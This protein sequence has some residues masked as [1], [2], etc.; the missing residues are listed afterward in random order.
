ML[1]LKDKIRTIPNFPKPGIMFRD[2]TTLLQ[3][4]DSLRKLTDIFYERYKEVKIDAIAGIESRG[5]ILAGILAEK[6]NTGLI[7][8]RK[9]GK[10]PYETIKQE[11]SLEYG[12][13]TLEIHKDAIQPGQN[14][15]L[16]D[17]L[18]ATGGTAL[19][20]CKLIEKLG[21]KIYEVAFIID[22]PD[23]KGKQKLSKYNVFTLIEF[24]GE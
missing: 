3:D 17:D 18:I 24:I 16:V 14:I 10:L 9:P 23:L 1:K 22:L 15:L 11:Y 7:L 20:S 5:F 21:G 6:L 4:K 12:I 2:I 8:I 13:D 19:A